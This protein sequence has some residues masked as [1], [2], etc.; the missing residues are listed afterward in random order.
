MAPHSVVPTITGQ[1]P[2][3]VRTENQ[4][5]DTSSMKIR[6]MGPNSGTENRLGMLTSVQ[7]AMA[8]KRGAEARA[9]LMRLQ[10]MA[11]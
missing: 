9:S 6:S 7:G 10:A 5:A 8:A 2:G 1:G 11:M 4:N 3:T